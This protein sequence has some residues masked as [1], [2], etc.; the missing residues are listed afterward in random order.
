MSTKAVI[1][2]GLTPGLLSAQG[3]ATTYYLDLKLGNN[4]HAG[5]QASAPWQTLRYASSML[6]HPGDQIL[7]KAGSVWRW[8]ILWKHHSQRARCRCSLF[9]LLRNGS[10]QYHQ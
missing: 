1:L 6:Y 5:A 8:L 4:F 2:F 7:F 9:R 3:Q 10:Q